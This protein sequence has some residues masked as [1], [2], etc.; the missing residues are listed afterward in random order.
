LLRRLKHKTSLDAAWHV[1]E[2]AGLSATL[3]Y[4]GP[5][6]DV[7]RAGTMSGVPANGY[8][9]VNLAGSYDL[10]NG[11]TAYARIDNLLDRHYQDPIGFLR[12]GL[13]VYAGLRVALDATRRPGR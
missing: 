1:T 9:L 11:L 7:N 8:T 12:P 10:G 6:L 2:A 4:V 13:G 5:W 3:L